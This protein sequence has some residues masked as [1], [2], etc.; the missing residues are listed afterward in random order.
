MS[1]SYWPLA[2]PAQEPR[3]HSWRVI[4]VLGTELATLEVIKDDGTVY[5]PDCDL[6]MRRGAWEWYRHRGYD[7][8]SPRGETLWRRG[9]RR[10]DW[11]VDTVTRTVLTCDRGNF[12]LHAELDAYEGEKRIFAKNWDRTIPRDLV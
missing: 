3:E 12:Y 9:F 10:G 1:T 11:Q 6:E 8:D 7:F 5:I 2:W 4:R